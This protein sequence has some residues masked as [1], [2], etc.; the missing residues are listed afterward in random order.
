MPPAT[1]H[2]SAEPSADP[3]QAATRMSPRLLIALCAL[4]VLASTAA[5]TWVAGA[6][7]FYWDDL[8]LH[9][10]AAAQA[11]PDAGYLLSD[12]DGHLMPGGMALIWLAAHAAPLDFRIPLLQ[13]AL[14]QLIA[15]AAVVRMLWVL[16]RGR[17]VLLLPLVVALVLPLGLPAA[18]W[19]SAALNSLPLVASMA[20]AVAS[21][22]RL[23]QTG[24][25]R[26]AVAA[27]AA[28][29]V[30]LVFVEKAVLVPV[31]SALALLGWWWT[32]WRGDGRNGIVGGH[33]GGRVWR[34][35]RW[36][37]AAQALVLAAWAAVFA[38]TV[39]RIGGELW[40]GP[41]NAGTT[42]GPPGL[43][44]PGPSPWGLIDATYRHAVAPTLAGGPWRWERWH[45]GPPMADPPVAAVVAGAL[46]CALVLAWSLTTRRRTGSV[47]AVVAVYPLVSVA[48]ILMGRAGPDTANEIVQTLRYH[49]DVVVVLAVA[50]GL[51]LAAPRRHSPE[52]SG[53][54]DPAPRRAPAWVVPARFER[55]ALAG[56]VGLVVVSSSY[57]TVTYRAAWAEQ[58]SRDYLVPLLDSLHDRRAPMLDADVPLEVLLP[59]TYPA[60]RLSS[61]LAG[62]SDI[63]EIGAWTTEPVTVDEMGRLHPAAVVPGRMIPQGAEPGCGHRVSAGGTRIALDGPLLGR[64]W[65]VQFNYFS[66]TDGTVAVR[67]DEGQ[68][69]DVPVTAG[70]STRFVRVE[71][72]GT[73]VTVTPGEGLPDLCI[74]SGPVGVLVPR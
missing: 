70:L 43:R 30:G 37:W 41:D 68:T 57:S 9:G 28:T 64:D 63:P 51:V 74:G 38:L 17:P 46:V 18:T 52:S 36:M 12:H 48:L 73:G 26:H 25:R 3:A 72:S 27:V 23:A 66:G 14:L 22:I 6:G 21:T 42:P 1:H 7:W 4:V 45:P 2:N 40:A 61:L 54:E 31:V 8:V 39:G 69:I 24:R 10:R 56:L 29:V 33:S 50:L 20:W 47:W 53:R 58:P 13:I 49:P 44:M 16:L 67:L 19:W 65:V 62:V 60:N 55:W 35:T 59:V 71:G 5:R 15:G 11:L 34:R 32:S